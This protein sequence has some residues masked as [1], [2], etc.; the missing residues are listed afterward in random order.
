MRKVDSNELNRYLRFG[1]L[2]TNELVN[3][4]RHMLTARLFEEELVK[5]KMQEPSPIPGTVLDGCGAEALSVGAT[6]ALE[7]QDSVYFS[8]RDAGGYITR[9]VDIYDL[10]LQYFT[11]ANSPTHGRDLNWHLG[12]AGKNIL[13]FISHMAA[14]AP[15]LSG[16]VWAD[17]YLGSPGSVGMLFIG[18]GGSN[19]GV[20]WETMNAA[21]VMKLP[22]VWIFNLN[23]Y[24]ISTLP[25]ETHPFAA[26]TKNFADRAKAFDMDGIFITSG[27]DVE[28][29]YYRTKYAVEK[30]RLGFGPS[31]IVAQTFRL[32]GHNR[33]EP[34]NYMAFKDA[35]RSFYRARDPIDFAEFVLN[36]KLELDDIIDIR[37]QIEAQVH[38]AIQRALS[39][40]DPEPTMVGLGSAFSKKA[41]EDFVLIENSD[42][43]LLYGQAITEAL[44]QAMTDDGSIIVFGED[45][46]SFAEIGGRGG[47]Y[48][49][50]K[51]LTETFGIARCFNT[52]ISEA[53][54]LGFAAGLA[55]KGLKPIAEIQFF[56]FLSAG[57]SQLVDII[58]TH[59]YYTGINLPIVI[60]VPAG[61]I[62]S[63]GNF[64]SFMEEASIL[65]FPGLKV[66]FPSDAYTAKGLLLSA[67]QDPDPVVFIE[68]IHAY[69]R[70]R[71]SSF[72]PTDKYFYPIGKA[73]LVREGTDVSIIT[74]GALMVQMAKEAAE[75]LQENNISVEILDLLTLRPLDTEAIINTYR[76][77]GRALILHEATGFG[78]FSGE[79]TKVLASPE[80]RQYHR[81]QGSEPPILT[82]AARE[83]F[84]PGSPVLENYRLPSTDEIIDTVKVLLEYGE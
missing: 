35:E 21:A 36:S 79:I 30:A 10:A 77:T 61:Y 73:R 43:S 62:P 15:M 7:K 66:V 17:R 45:V 16:V 82:L 18:E 13:K 69:S 78:G 75:Q 22:I 49:I 33:T 67:I 32:E 25:E 3:L 6:A 42:R 9:G 20:L 57:Y 68:Q 54:I 27:Y 40:P 46:K 70:K 51:S 38:D 37:S 74:Y 52:P 19:N 64:H 29:V 65:N 23:S 84:V 4:Y 58:A 26:P 8:H 12:I 63:S 5:L 24:A 2:S 50:T 39:A 28:E 80:A 83:T 1:Y 47:V 71:Y 81:W 76:N 41:I 44:S 11:K 59:Y 34:T 56:P 72:V 53:W 48:G 60:R 55:Y 14:G 31:M